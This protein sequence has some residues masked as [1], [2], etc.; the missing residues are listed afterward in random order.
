[1]DNVILLHYMILI[2]G[3]NDNNLICYKLTLVLVL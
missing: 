1:M 3:N 2:N